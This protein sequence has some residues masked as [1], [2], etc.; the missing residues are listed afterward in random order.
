VAD[1][2][3]SE[4]REY[5]S[6]EREGMNDDVEAHGLLDRPVD[7]APEAARDDEGDDVEAHV[8]SESPLD[9]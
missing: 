7:P 8:L 6:D 4:E 3:K 5:N 1:E 2:G 9:T